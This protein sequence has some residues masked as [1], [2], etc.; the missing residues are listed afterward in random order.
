MCMKWQITCKQA[1][2]FV[3]K[4]QEGKLSLKNRYLLWVH[5][6]ICSFCKLFKIQA[7]FIAKNSRHMHEHIDEVLTPEEKEKMIAN[8]QKQ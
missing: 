3:I 7:D 1:T 2:E 8:L 6:G 5:M 4:R